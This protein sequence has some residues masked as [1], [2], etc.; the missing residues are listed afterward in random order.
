MPAPSEATI[1]LN[2]MVVLDP[3]RAKK[4]ILK[5]FVKSHCVREKTA[6]AFG[7]NVWTLGR[8]IRKLGLEKTLLK[9]SEELQEGWHQPNKA[10]SK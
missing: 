6:E 2:A 4:E 7:V 5:A 3:E 10:T 9:K 1:R 8:Y